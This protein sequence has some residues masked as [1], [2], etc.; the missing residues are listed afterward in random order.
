MTRKRTIHDLRK[1]ARVKQSDWWSR[2]FDE[3]FFM[4]LSGARGVN[5]DYIF[6]TRYT[7]FA[8]N[9]FVA[10]DSTHTMYGDAA[11]RRPR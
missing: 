4:Y 6:G 10:P 2:I 5:T 7:G 3:L 1:I 9:P 8:N 11:P